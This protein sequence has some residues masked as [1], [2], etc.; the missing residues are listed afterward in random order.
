MAVITRFAPSPT[1]NLHIGSARTA[2]YSYLFASNL[3]GK[4]LL[5]IEDTDRSRSTQEA[6]EVIING[7]KW[8]EI[9]WDGDIIYQSQR[10][11]R[12][13]EIAKQLVDLGH[14]YYSTADGDDKPAIR[15]K[16]P[17]DNEISFND[18]V[19]GEM[20]FQPCDLN[21]FV[22]VRSD[23]VATYML[24]VVVDDIDMN[25]T[26]IIRGSD[27]ISN[28]PKQII[29]YNYL[30]KIPPKFGHI[31]LIHDQSGQKLSKRKHPTSIMDYK[32]KGYL[33][34]ALRNYILRLGWNNINASEFLSDEEMIEKFG[35]DGV[36]RSPAKFDLD[37][38]NHINAHYIK[39]LSFDELYSLTKVFI[40]R[41]I[42][43]NLSESD[44]LL[45]IKGYDEAKKVDTLLDSARILSYFTENYEFDLS[46][47]S[48]DLI[49][50]NKD[51]LFDIKKFLNNADY[52]NFSESFKY[53]LKER[54]L[55]FG[56]IGPVLRSLMIGI[57]SSVNIGTLF[58]VI[59]KNEA[60]KRFSLVKKVLNL[61]IDN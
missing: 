4:M 44:K 28:T 17:Q 2:L 51:L 55:K 1:G 52:E 57:P 43:R 27:H 7:L 39:E 20:S 50:K 25:I 23:G 14:A 13:V 61:D 32:E 30:K 35:I 60:L 12:Y 46:Q 9:E 3:G 15:I 45:L 59:G 40:E 54:S 11:D 6:T 48:A 5:R 58:Q 42:A 38:L 41:N 33:P 16:I 21:D 26:H 10:N 19:Y 29:I 47:E 22:I 37:K 49:N 36:G 53:F 34:I 31:P 8:L 56:E 24:A 18:L